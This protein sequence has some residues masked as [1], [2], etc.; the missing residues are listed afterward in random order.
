MATGPDNP[1]ASAPPGLRPYYVPGLNS[2]NYTSLPTPSPYYAT[3]EMDLIDS[4]VAAREL[5]N[6]AVLK[7]IT[8]AVSCPFEVSRTLLQVQYTPSE[9]GRVAVAA[10]ATDPDADDLADE[11]NN[12]RCDKNE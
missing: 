4:R 1:F 8:T 9:E 11:V 5:I 7:Y 10:S 12:G 3:E 6:Y 2:P